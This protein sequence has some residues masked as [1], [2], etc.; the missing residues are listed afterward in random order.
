[1]SLLT[2]KFPSLE[3]ILNINILA[4]LC[5]KKTAS[6]PNNVPEYLLRL[7]LEKKNLLNSRVFLLYP[8]RYYTFN[9]WDWN[10]T[11]RCKNVKISLQSY[12]EGPMIF[13]MSRFLS[14]DF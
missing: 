4:I 1:M 13:L 8:Q 6:P 11:V 9:T 5:A 12:N 10:R 2:D 7:S 3:I 14:F